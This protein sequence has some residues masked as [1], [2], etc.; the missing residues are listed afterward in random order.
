MSTCNRCGEHVL[1]VTT[2]KGKNVSLE[3]EG[4][5]ID[6]YPSGTFVF[7]EEGRC[8][9]TGTRTAEDPDV[10]AGVWHLCHFD[11]CSGR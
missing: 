5:D 9:K 4:G 10:K 11:S 2:V 6:D 3:P 8:V 7:N 1:W